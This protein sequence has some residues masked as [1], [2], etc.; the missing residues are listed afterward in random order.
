LSHTS[1]VQNVNRQQRI[2]YVFPH[3]WFKHGKSTVDELYYQNRQLI[4]E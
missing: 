3:T 4:A 2:S 1:N